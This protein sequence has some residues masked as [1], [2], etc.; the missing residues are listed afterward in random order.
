MSA[1]IAVQDEMLPGAAV[2]NSGWKLNG[3][4]EQSAIEVVWKP[5]AAEPCMNPR[6]CWVRSLITTSMALPPP[7]A[8]ASSRW[9]LIV[10]PGFM[11]SVWLFG[12]S[13]AR[14]AFCGAGA[15]V[16]MP[17]F[18]TNANCSGSSQSGLHCAKPAVHSALS[19]VSAAHQCVE[20]QLSLSANGG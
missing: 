4:P 13:V 1:A 6:V 5:L 20:S 14:V 18:C 8:G 3:V 17:S 16:G 7:G 12:T 11:S 15:P 9:I 10:S 2:L 19:I